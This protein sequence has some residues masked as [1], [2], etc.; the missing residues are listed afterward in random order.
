M[1]GNQARGDHDRSVVAC[2]R[3]GDESAFSALVEH[4][5]RE[6]HARRYR[7]LGS[8][9]DAAELMKETYLRAWLYRIAANA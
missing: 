1:T 5:R 6:L 2:L 3:E 4:Y 7:I 9:E 8:F